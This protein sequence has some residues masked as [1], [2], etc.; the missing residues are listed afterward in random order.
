MTE[1]KRKQMVEANKTYANST[2]SISDYLSGIDK[3]KPKI[4]LHSFECLADAIDLGNGDIEITIAKSPR[5]LSVGS[6]VDNGKRSLPFTQMIIVHSN[7]GCRFLC[8]K[9]DKGTPYCH[10]ATL[11][12]LYKD[13]PLPE[14]KAHDLFGGGGFV[15]PDDNRE[16]PKDFNHIRKI[17]LLVKDCFEIKTDVTL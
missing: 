11:R 17:P 9:V 1:E 3:D 13:T 4:D 16:L 6:Y 7:S 5:N 2:K 12:M 8:V 10:T 15:V 14:I